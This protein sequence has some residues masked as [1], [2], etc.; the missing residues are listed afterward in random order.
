MALHPRPKQHLA[1][2]VAYVKHRRPISGPVLALRF[3]RRC[4]VRGYTL[5]RRFRDM[6]QHLSIV[7]V[8]V[9]WRIH[10][11]SAKRLRHPPFFV[12]RLN[13]ATNLKQDE[14]PRRHGP[15]QEGR[16]QSEGDLAPACKD[17]RRYG[18]SAGPPRPCVSL[19]NEAL[20]SRFLDCKQGMPMLASQKIITHAEQ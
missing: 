20:V 14:E 9:S 10:G 8:R 13:R 4:L 2:S 12:S 17:R 11:T 16:G 18:T 15:D 3:S 6:L 1:S 19:G 5:L 7:I